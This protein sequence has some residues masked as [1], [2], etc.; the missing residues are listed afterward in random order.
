MR[1]I[2][3]EALEDL[4][5]WEGCVLYAYDDADASNPKRFIEPGMNVRGTLTIG[6]GHTETV[7]PGMR[8]T[9][10]GAENLLKRDLIPVERAINKIIRV[11]LTDGQFGALCSFAYNLGH[12]TAPGSP[13]ANVAQN[14]N[15]GDYAGAIQR[16]QLYNKQRIN[17]RLVTVPGLVNRRSA[18][19]GLWARGDHVSSANVQ[20]K[21]G[22]E[23]VAAVVA[24]T[25]TGKAAVG[26]G[27]VGVAATVVQAA[28]AVEA[29]G[30]LGPV[31]GV[32]LILVAATLFILW[33]KGKI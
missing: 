7:R 19:A 17:G 22:N 13:L 6:Y 8:I 11:P 12:S 21:A 26:M 28:P 31:V 4:K 1:Q 30:V 10:D 2:S 18:E 3:P 20:A 9:E 16:M 27:A 24:D 32:V 5:R 23:T 29:L 15:K 14:I 25:N 33:R